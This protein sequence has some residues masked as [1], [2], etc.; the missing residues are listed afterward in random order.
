MIAKVL[1]SKN[2]Y[3]AYRQVVGNQG[4]AGVDGME[5]NGL[6]FFIDQYKPS[7]LT[8]ILSREYVPKAIRGVEIPKSNRKTRLLGIPCVVDRWL[9]QGVS[10]QLAVQFE[11]DFEEESYGFRPGKNLHGAVTQSLNN[12]ND[13]YQDIVDIDLKGFFDE[14]QH[15][16]LLQLIYNKVKCPTILWLIRKWLRA[17]IQING[18]LH[19]RRKGLPQGSP[20]SPLLSNIL[21]DKLDKY[22]K[23][24]GLKFVRYADDFSVYTKSKAEA[25]KVG[26]E[27]YLFLKNKLEL[28]INREKSGIRRPTKFVLLGHGF[29]PTYGKREKGDYQL[30]VKKGSWENLRR[31]LKGITKKTLPY[32]FKVR[33]YKLREVWMGWINN[34]RLANI[35]S[36]LIKLDEWLRNRLRYCIWHDWKKPVRKRKNL[37]RLG[38]SQ[39]LAYAWSRTRKGGWAVAQSPILGTTITLSR[40]RRKGYQS[41]QDYYLKFKPEIQ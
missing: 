21:L 38:V 3:R 15:Y 2:L 37:I 41:M 11:L 7:L 19:K 4:S 13:G 27:V 18:K 34:Y 26:N 30:V 40:L 33:L 17:P 1:Q 16:K 22:L 24:K 35:K 8:K 10:Q 9:Q 32:S 6:K 20:L 23:S 5:V 31:K 39:G 14:V 28:P 25:R 12:I 36:K 29:T